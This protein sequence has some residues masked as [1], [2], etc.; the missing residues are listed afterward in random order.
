MYTLAELADRLDGCLYGYAEQPIRS[1]ASLSRATKT[2]LS[3]YD[4]PSLRESLIATQAGAVLLTETN[5][6]HCPVN[7]IVVANPLLS[8]TIATELLMQVGDREEAGIHQTAS[9][10]SSALIGSQVGIGAN[11]VIAEEVSLGDGVQIAANCVIEAGVSIGQGTLV[12]SGVYVHSGSKLGER[13]VIE[14]GAILGAS[15][16]NSIKMQGRWHS[17]PAVGGVIISDE[18][19]LGANTVIARGALGD[20]Y[21]GKGVH[22]DNLV[23]V[24][25]DVTIGAN[26]AIAGCAAIGAYARIGSHCIIGGASCIAAEVHLVDDVVITGMSTVSKSLSK[27]GV[28]SSGIM[29]SEHQR[30]RRNVARF[31]RLDD[32]MMRLTRLEKECSNAHK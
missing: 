4:N 8:M 24:A 29:V 31:R 5:A 21:L 20:T 12:H 2:D 11:T 25:H 7:L 30:W 14:S 16:F 1:V 6:K 26:T 28:Y 18:V 17:G 32:Y 19:H 13:V 22:I 10:S 27:S 15:P 23:Q 9:I 3:Y